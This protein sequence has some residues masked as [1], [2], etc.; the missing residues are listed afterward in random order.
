MPSVPKEN[1]AVASAQFI[2]TGTVRKLNASTM[3]HIPK[4]ERTAVVRINDVIQGPEVLRHCVGQDITVQVGGPKKL[5]KG[6]Q[7][8]FYAD[9]VSFGESIAVHSRDHDDVRP[10]ARGQAAA[11]TS[12]PAVNLS[13]R[14]T[15]DRF[16]A[17]ELV[18]SGKVTGIRLPELNISAKVAA[19]TGAVAEVPT[20]QRISEHD[21]LWQEAV[22]EVET[23]H[24][25]ADPGKT[26]TLRFP[27]S[28]DVMWYQAT[29]FHPGHHGVFMLH[30]DEPKAIARPVVGAAVEIPFTALHP[31]DFHPSDDPKAQSIIQRVLAARIPQR[32]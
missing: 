14:R 8:T 23:V 5:S 27:A 1:P 17:A 21:P 31:E 2:F 19:G 26:V 4:T 6:Q 32:S 29:K 12:D 13:Q 28:T 9:D 3:A 24:K 10:S 11:P 20:P 15:E 18:V 30:R 25:G 16:E 22:I 7:A